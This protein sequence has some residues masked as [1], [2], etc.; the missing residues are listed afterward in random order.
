MAQ[1]DTLKKDTADFTFEDLRAHF[2][3]GRS[4]I[5][6]GSGRDAVYGY[7]SGIM[8]NIG[9]IEENEW[10]QLMVDLIIRSG[11]TALQEQLRLWAKEHCAWLHTK[12]EVERYALEIHATRLFDNPQW[13]D[14]E[15]F[16][17]EYRS[18]C[19]NEESEK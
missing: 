12:K 8:T 7:R 1:T 3:T 18:Q 13:A 6:S 5:K 2:G 15:L 14:Y 10:A 19:R 17:R 9:D 11:E 4:Y 16:N